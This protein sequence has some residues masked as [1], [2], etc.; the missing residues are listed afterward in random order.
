[1]YRP[2]Q[3]PQLDAFSMVL[4]LTCRGRNV[5]DLWHLVT[6]QGCGQWHC[7]RGCQSIVLVTIC[8]VK[9]F[10]ALVKTKYEGRAMWKAVCDEYGWIWCGWLSFALDYRI[11][12]K[13]AYCT[14]CMNTPTHGWTELWSP[15]IEFW[16]WVPIKKM[17]CKRNQ[18]NLV[19]SEFASVVSIY[20]TLF[21]IILGFQR[22]EISSW[23]RAEC[24][25]VYLQQLQHASA[26]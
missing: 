3:D 20:C 13:Y 5:P 24:R 22:Y 1:M 15:P 16:S 25:H 6:C 17:C 23:H 26:L 19:H 12:M 7:S 21:I 8:R 10:L 9:G 11:T 4:S 2:D 18:T 14:Q